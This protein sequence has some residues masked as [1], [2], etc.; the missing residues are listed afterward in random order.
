MMCAAWQARD[1]KLLGQLTEEEV[2]VKLP[3]HL[4]YLPDAI[5]A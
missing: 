5:A 3:V 4:R 1:F 2:S